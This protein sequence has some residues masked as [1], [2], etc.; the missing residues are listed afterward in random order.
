[1]II[2]ITIIII[3]YLVIYLL[4]A[5]QAGKTCRFCNNLDGEARVEVNSSIYKYKKDADIE[6]KD[7]NQCKNTLPLY[8][9]YIHPHGEPFELCKTY[10]DYAIEYRNTTN[11]EINY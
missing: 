6:L 7:C 8:H 10:V 1:M 5:P 4:Y 3:I 2:I 9:Y 11:C